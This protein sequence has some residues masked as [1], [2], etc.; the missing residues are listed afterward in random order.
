MN[1]VDFSLEIINTRPLI[2]VKC[3]NCK[4]EMSAFEENYQIHEE[5]C[6]IETGTLSEK[7]IERFRKYRPFEC[8]YCTDE[9]ILSEYSYMHHLY[10]KHYEQLMREMSK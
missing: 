5:K 2:K 7:E 6:I 3:P 1:E 4:L 9:F 8:G 10:V